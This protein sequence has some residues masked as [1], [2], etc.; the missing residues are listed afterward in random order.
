MLRR[1]RLLWIV[2]RWNL[3][4]IAV[5]FTV[6]YAALWLA[7]YPSSP[8]PIPNPAACPPYVIG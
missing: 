4:W 8:I 6:V 7:F 1:A 5:I 3:V 2:F